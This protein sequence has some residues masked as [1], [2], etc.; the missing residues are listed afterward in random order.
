MIDAFEGPTAQDAHVA[1]F[2]L[3]AGKGVTVAA[4]KWDLV[5]G[6]EEVAR[7]EHHLARIFHFLPQSP[8]ARISAKTGRN[9]DH[10]LPMALEIHRT[11]GQRIP[12]SRLN[13]F[14]R[15]WVGRRDLPSRRGRA[16]RF[17]Y[18]TQTGTAPPEFTLFFSNPEHVH[19]SYA[20]YLE[21]GLRQEFG[22]D[23]TPVRLSLRAS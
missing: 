9:L 23:G 15:A 20:R 4:N 1:G 22:F 10:V 8:L 11:R 18:A 3:D 14:L 5:R 17:K 19:R 2:V 13:A 12:T 7:V 21:N 16:A 6:K